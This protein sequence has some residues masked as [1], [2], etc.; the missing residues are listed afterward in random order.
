[1]CFSS[2]S[3]AIPCS[4]PLPSQVIALDTIKL[5]MDMCEARQRYP[6]G[7]KME[8]KTISNIKLVSRQPVVVSLYMDSPGLVAWIEEH[9]I[10]QAPA[11]TCVHLC[12]YLLPLLII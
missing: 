12:Y 3:P 7:I 1:M 5:V 9:H 4:L 2:I 6:E 8:T 11:H 10:M